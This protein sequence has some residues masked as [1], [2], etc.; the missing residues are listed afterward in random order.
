M[1]CLDATVNVK[2]E[3]QKKADKFKISVL[4]SDGAEVGKKPWVLLGF[5]L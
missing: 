4:R 5:Q 3:A 1:K 2:I